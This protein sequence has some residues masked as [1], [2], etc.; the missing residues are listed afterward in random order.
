MKIKTII[1]PIFLLLC[2]FSSVRAEDDTFKPEWS[3]GVNSGIT[4][5]KV[6]FSSYLRVPQKHL[7]QFTGGIMARYISEE[8][9]GIVGELNFSMRGWQERTDT[10]YLN[11]Y[12]R[13][14]SYIELPV[15]TQLYFN[16]GRRL[17]L[18]FNAGPQISYSTGERT[19][20]MFIDDS[21]E[22]K[23]DRQQY[24]TQ[25]VQHRIDYGI[26]GGGGFELRTG[27]GS[28]ILDANYFFGLSDIFRN[29]RADIFQASSNQ[30]ISVRL[31]YL[32]SL[33]K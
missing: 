32:Y 22:Y 28:F 20:E 26:R 16:L 14:L 1:I 15:M 7:R 33:I 25:S 5:S 27:A 18:I 13:S 11:R 23:D 4:L 29:T 30:I 8:H 21:E 31:S 10:T 6:G 24:Y 17:R 9:F 12:T 19:V 3:F 2:I